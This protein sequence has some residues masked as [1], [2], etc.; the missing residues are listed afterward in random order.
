MLPYD[1]VLLAVPAWLSFV[2]YRMKAIPSP[3]PLWSAVALA[4]VIDLGGS[5][6][7]VAPIV[8]LAGLIWYGRLYLQRAP[9]PPAAIAA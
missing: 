5:F 6:G 3:A 8:L 2:L 7:S 9:A 1:S 4:L